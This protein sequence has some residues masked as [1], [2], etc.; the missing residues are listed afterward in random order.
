MSKKIYLA[1]SVL[2]ACLWLCFYS[3]DKVVEGPVH[4]MTFSEA[5]AKASKNPKPIM[6]D[7]YTT[8]C[9]PCKMM[10]S[11]TFGNTTIAEYL[12]KNYYCVKFDAETFDTVK[13]SIMVPDSVKD[14]NGKLIK[15]NKKQQPLTFINNAP[16]GTKRSPHQFAASILD[17]QLSYPSIVFLNEDV[18]RIHTIKGFHPPAQF[19]PIMKFIGSGAYKN[20]NYDLYMKSFQ[21][22]LH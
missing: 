3:P 7:I 17:G 2:I 14:K 16:V 15:V 5:V 8:W 20:Q 6:V 22:E 12:N 4:W 13:F 11:Q 9:G 1:L 10:S 21:T 19:E 18:Q